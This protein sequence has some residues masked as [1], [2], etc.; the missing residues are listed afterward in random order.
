[1][2]ALLLACLSV[3]AAIEATQAPRRTSAACQAALETVNWVREKLADPDL[4]PGRLEQLLAVMELRSGSCPTVGDLWA[5]R[6]VVERALKR[7]AQDVTYSLT[8]ARELGAS[9]LESVASAEATP[10]GAEDLDPRAPVRDKWAIVVGVGTFKDSRVRALSL[11]SKDARDLTAVITNPDVG[12]F[13]KDNVRTLLDDEATLPNIRRAIGWVRERAD[14]NDLVLLFFASH[15]SP[16]ELDPNGV[17]YILTN[18]T[19]TTDGASLYGTSLQMIDL[20]ENVSRDIRAARV[21]LVLDTCYSGAATI[22]HHRGLKI[23]K[24]PAATYSVALR[25]LMTTPGRAVLASSQA[26]EQSMESPQRQNGYFTHFLLEGLRK[27][28][29][30]GTLEELFAFVRDRVSTTVRS[31][32]GRE[33]NPVLSWGPRA[34][35]IVLSTR[36]TGL[37]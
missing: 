10:K 14:P 25:K 2:R 5:Y 8:K 30:G 15:G 34:D 3:G 7:P 36:T 23:V 1:M 18:D 31:E 21:V 32:L 17:S 33:Q 26:D 35:Q 22:S 16:R 4:S 9:N 6:A 37:Q 11:A 12:R 27:P 24:E 28:S 19:D 20:V 13:R 29:G